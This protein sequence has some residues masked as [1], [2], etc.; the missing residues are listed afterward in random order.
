MLNI[1]I[2]GMYYVLLSVVGKL[3]IFVGF[4]IVNIMYNTQTH[5]NNT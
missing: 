5:L 4:G 1:H 2:Y 3:R